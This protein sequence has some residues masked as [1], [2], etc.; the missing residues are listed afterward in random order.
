[1]GVSDVAPPVPSPETGTPSPIPSAEYGRG[2]GLRSPWV[3][4]LPAVTFEVAVAGMTHDGLYRFG[5]DCPGFGAQRVAPREIC[6]KI[7]VALTATLN[8]GFPA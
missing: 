4:A 8:N 6:A 1:M 5:C 2:R 7:G 3:R